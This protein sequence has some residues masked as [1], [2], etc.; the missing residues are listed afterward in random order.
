[1]LFHHRNQEEIKQER[2]QRLLNLIYETKAS[3]D[4][5]KETDELF[6]RLMQVR[7]FIIEVACKNKNICTFTELRANLRYM[8]N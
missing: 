8:V 7:N 4:H 2:D 5:A 3:W 1:M 6:M